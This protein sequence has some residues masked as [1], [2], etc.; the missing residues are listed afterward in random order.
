MSNLTLKRRKNNKKTNINNEQIYDSFNENSPETTPDKRIKKILN[1]LNSNNVFKVI[2]FPLFILWFEIMLHVFMNSNMKY[3]P[4]YSLF[5]FSLGFLLSAVLLIIPHK[6]SKFISVISAVVISLIYTIEF[7]ARIIVQT[8]YQPS[9]LGVAFE[10]NLAD[11][12]DVI[13]D[14]ILSNILFIILAIPPS[15]SFFI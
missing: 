2:S 5:S 7:I 11:Y 6:I 15:L 1:G 13:I 9:T 14:N 8:Y 10:N 3:M 4:V 12:S